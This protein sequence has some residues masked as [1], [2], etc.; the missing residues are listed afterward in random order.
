V[1]DQARLRGGDRRNGR[2]QIDHHRRAPIVARRAR[3]Q[4]AHPT[5]AE[6]CTVEAVFSGDD[7]AKLNSQL[8]EAGVEPSGEDLIIKPHAFEQ[9]NKSPIHQRFA[10][11]IVDLE[12]LGDELVDLHGPHDHQ[13]LLSP[14]KQWL[15]STVSRAPRKRWPTTKNISRSCNRSMAEHAALNTAETAREQELDLLRHQINEITSAKLVE[16]E[17]D[18]ISS[19]YK[20][21]SN[22]KRLI[23]LASGISQRLPNLTTHAFAAGR[24]ATVAARAGKNR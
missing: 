4:I 23:E 9:R 1:A 14:E 3:G 2:G 18:E 24:N 16:G 13:S 11:D 20:L 21:A 10:Y 8:I 19:R 7:V 12:N 17:E 6:V 22:S 15:C 5:G